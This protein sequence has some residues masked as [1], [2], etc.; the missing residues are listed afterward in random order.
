MRSED[1][2]EDREQSS[3]VWLEVPVALKPV[4][5]VFVL[6]MLVPTLVEVSRNS[7]SLSSIGRMQLDSHLFARSE[8]LI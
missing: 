7:R 4:G 8:L 5:L 6:I 2:N 3:G 1:T